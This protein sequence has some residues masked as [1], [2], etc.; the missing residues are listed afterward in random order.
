[1]VQRV[2]SAAIKCV[3]D[4]R[5]QLWFCGVKSVQNVECCSDYEAQAKPITIPKKKFKTDFSVHYLIL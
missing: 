4:L 2:I 5:V 3:H 1:M